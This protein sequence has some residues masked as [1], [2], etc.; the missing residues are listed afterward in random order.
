MSFIK[1]IRSEKELI[2]QRLYYNQ[3][4]M[5]VVSLREWFIST[6]CSAKHLLMNL[7]LAF[8]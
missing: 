1:D 4:F 7:M 5:A 3:L 8:R 6:E 2:E